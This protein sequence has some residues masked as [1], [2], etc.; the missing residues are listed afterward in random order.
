M[1]P[2]IHKIQEFNGVRFYKKP[3][4][5]YKADRK[6]GG[7]YMHRYVWQHYFGPIPE[8]HQVHHKNHLRADNAIENLELQLSVEHAKHHSSLADKELLREHMETVMRPKAVE[9][10]KSDAA[11]EFHSAL[12]KHSWRVREKSEYACT[13]CGGIFVA[14]VN[15]QKAGFC[16]AKCQSAARR[17]SG[18]DDVQCKCAGCGGEF[19]KNKYAKTR[20]C[21]RS[22]AAKSRLD[23]AG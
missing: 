4:G 2:V 10:H 21:S 1:R 13:H 9:W 5:Y 20:F 14:Y 11:K 22:C 8:G 18:A 15:A 3:S 23:S 12:G 17:A 7:E 16:S 6:D 19:T